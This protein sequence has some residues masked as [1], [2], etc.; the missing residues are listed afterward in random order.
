MSTS[1]QFTYVGCYSDRD[2]NQRKGGFNVEP[3]Y[4]PRAMHRIQ[5]RV[6]SLDAC[7]HKARELGYTYFGMQHNH[8]CYGSNTDSFAHYSKESD[9]DCQLE[10]TGV[11]GKGSRVNHPECGGSWRNAVYRTDVEA[12]VPEPSPPPPPLPEPQLPP[13]TVPPP[14]VPPPTVPPTTGP[15]SSMVLPRSPST[16]HSSSTRKT[17]DSESDWNMWLMGGIGMLILLLIGLFF[18]MQ[19][20]STSP[21][22]NQRKS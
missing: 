19:S 20:R 1:P 16:S 3:R 15:S 4:G 18:Y 22:S 2:P 5:S 10:C 17:T 9:E 14:T 7:N 8:E 13:P 12:P 6:E 21:P 11:P